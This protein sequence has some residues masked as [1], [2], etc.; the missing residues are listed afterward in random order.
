MKKKKG[1]TF[2]FLSFFLFYFF[3][4]FFFLERK[5]EN[6]NDVSK[7]IFT[8][9]KTNKTEETSLS[10]GFIAQKRRRILAKMA[11]LFRRH[12]LRRPTCSTFFTFLTFEPFFSLSLLFTLANYFNFG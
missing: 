4:F 9:Y 7:R 1:M 12:L 10:S 2:L 8:S 5:W 6:K 3:F 11:L